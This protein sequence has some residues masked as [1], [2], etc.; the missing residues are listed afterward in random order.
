MNVP[1]GT[2]KTWVHQARRELIDQLQ[3]RGVVVERAS[4]EEKQHAVP[5][6]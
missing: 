5:R 1:L 4:A 2:V 6:I 3:R